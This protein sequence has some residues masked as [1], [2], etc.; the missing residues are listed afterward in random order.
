MSEFEDKLNSLLNDPE[1]MSRITEMAKSLMGGGGN[2]N[3]GKPDASGD[4][5]GEAEMM[6]R[7]MKLLKKS[8]TEE[9][10]DRT[11]LLNAMKPFL[12]SERRVK[13][14]KAMRLA[15]L[16]KLAELAAG[17]FGGDEDV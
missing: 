17:E 9:N 7:I 12:S 8:G 5:G 4:S 6:G 11:A 10:G 1:Q 3:E 13:M 2:E 14:D 15:K 16:A